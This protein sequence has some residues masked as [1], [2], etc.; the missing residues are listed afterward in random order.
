MNLTAPFMLNAGDHCLS[1]TCYCSLISVKG[2]IFVPFVKKISV[3]LSNEQD[4]FLYH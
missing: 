4:D 1:F 3:H 2:T